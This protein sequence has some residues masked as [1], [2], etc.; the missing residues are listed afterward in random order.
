MLMEPTWKEGQRSDGL[1]SEAGRDMRNDYVQP[2]RG[3]GDLV[4]FVECQRIFLLQ[5]IR[6][7]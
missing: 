4:G 7:E 3:V 1:G 2:A 6:V 5:K